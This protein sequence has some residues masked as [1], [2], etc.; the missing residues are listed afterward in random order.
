MCCF[1]MRVEMDTLVSLGIGSYLMRPRTVACSRHGRRLHALCRA[2]CDSGR[3]VGCLIIRLSI[4]LLSPRSPAVS[5]DIHIPF[6]PNPLAPGSLY[7]AVW[8]Q[9][10]SLC[11]DAVHILYA[12]PYS[13]FSCLLLFPALYQRSDGIQRGGPT[14]TMYLQMSRDGPSW[15]QR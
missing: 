13:T 8:L 12:S 9:R 4:P 6:S 7:Q 14:A 15:N 5:R 3:R 2:D 11:H 1:E 10:P